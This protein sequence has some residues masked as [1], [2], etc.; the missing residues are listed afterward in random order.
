ML[1]KIALLTLLLLVVITP[2]A[3]Q[4][5]DWQVWFYDGTALQVLTTDGLAE[6]IALPD[7]FGQVEPYHGLGYM[8]LS[9]DSSR[10]VFSRATS[11]VAGSTTVST[12]EIADLTNDTCCTVVTHP[13]TGDPLTSDPDT[14]IVGPFSPDGTQ[15]VAIFA[16]V[17]SG[18]PQSIVAVVDVARGDI[19]QQADVMKTFG[20]MGLLF[21][22]WDAEGVKVASTCL[23]CGGRVDDW[24]SNWDPVTGTITP[25]VQYFNLM[26]DKLEATGEYVIPVRNEDLPASNEDGMFPP[27]NAV[28]YLPDASQQTSALIYHD[29]AHIVIGSVDWVL[30]GQAYLVTEWYGTA[31]VVQRDGTVLTV[32]TGEAQGFIGATPDGWLMQN[33]NTQVVSYYQVRNGQINVTTWD[34]FPTRI[35]MLNTIASGDAEFPMPVPVVK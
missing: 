35:L 30:G 23:A 28:E 12:L 32:E 7:G 5:D 26:G 9:P 20:D 31:V 16:Q 3:A 11:A 8:A 4:T 14:V 17:Y 15:V 6:P 10:L 34:D 25:D 27:S 22:G 13:L 33:Y 2:A 21:G 19:V 18:T 29:P 1:R 24:M